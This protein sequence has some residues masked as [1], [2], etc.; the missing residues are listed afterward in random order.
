[1]ADCSVADIACSSAG[2]G[3]LT[4]LLMTR[5]SGRNRYHAT[6]TTT[7]A[8]PAS[9][10]VRVFIALFL[11]LGQWRGASLAPPYG[12]QRLSARRES[13]GP[14][15]EAGD[16]PEG[17]EGAVGLEAERVDRLHAAG[18]QHVQVA[19]VPAQRNVV[20]A[21]AYDGGRPARGA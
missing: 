10:D 21:A 11:S 2:N 15:R 17:H 14:C 16:G 8:V 3:S 9:I 7:T 18:L 6:P 12:G 1:M 13:S 20:H 19:A 4:V 5:A